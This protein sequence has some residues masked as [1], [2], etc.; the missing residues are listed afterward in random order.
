VGGP[1]LTE[2][3]LEWDC[4]EIDVSDVSGAKMVPWCWRS[5]FNVVI[6]TEEVK[7][8]YG[9]IKVLEPGRIWRTSG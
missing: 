9:C 2:E 3:L 1:F 5:L 8:G 6:S 4:G 7:K